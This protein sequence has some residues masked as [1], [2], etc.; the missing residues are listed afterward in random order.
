MPERGEF[1]S[2]EILGSHVYQS[3]VEV[4]GGGILTALYEYQNKK[5]ISANLAAWCSDLDWAPKCSGWG[6]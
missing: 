6:L 1:P 5:E 3:N 2:G 4:S